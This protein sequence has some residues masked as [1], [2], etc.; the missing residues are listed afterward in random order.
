MSYTTEIAEAD[1]LSSGD[2]NV[3]NTTHTSTGVF[4]PLKYRG[5]A[6]KVRFPDAYVSESECKSGELPIEVFKVEKLE[7]TWIRNICRFEA[8][9]IPGDFSITWAGDLDGDK[10]L[11]MLVQ[12]PQGPF[13]L[14][15]SSMPNVRSQHAWKFPNKPAC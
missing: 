4:L 9:D 6:Y 11:D 1:R 12:L 14:L 3:S 7:S 13:V 5:V 2:S 8:L 15:L 10:K